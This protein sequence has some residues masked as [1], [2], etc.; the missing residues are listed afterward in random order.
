MISSLKVNDKVKLINC[1]TQTVYKIAKDK[2]ANGKSLYGLG[3]DVNNPGNFDWYFES[4]KP[5]TWWANAYHS[6]NIIETKTIVE[7]IKE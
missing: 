7:I 5:V 3:L 6:K 1:T 2:N 4:G